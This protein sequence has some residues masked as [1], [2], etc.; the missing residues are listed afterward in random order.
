M[1]PGWCTG[2]ITVC[3]VDRHIQVT[4][5]RSGR[6]NSVMAFPYGAGDRVMHTYCFLCYYWTDKRCCLLW[7]LRHDRHRQQRGQDEAQKGYAYF[8]IQLDFSMLPL[9]AFNINGLNQSPKTGSTNIRATSL[10]SRHRGKPLT[11]YQLAY[12]QN[13]TCSKAVT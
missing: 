10:L 12:Q 11:P 9:K 13:L 2:A 5:V 8:F 4:V 1:W 6:H 7:W 3:G